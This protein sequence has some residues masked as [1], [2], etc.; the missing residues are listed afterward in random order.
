MAEGHQQEVVEG[1]FRVYKLYVEGSETGE[2][3]GEV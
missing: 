3:L 1:K 2:L